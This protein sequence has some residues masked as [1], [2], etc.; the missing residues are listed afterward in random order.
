MVIQLLQRLPIALAHHPA[1]EADDVILH[2][3][4]KAIATGEKRIIVVS[5]DSDFTQLLQLDARPIP[6]IHDTDVIVHNWRDKC[7]L[8]RP[9]FDYVLWKALRGDPTD[10]VPRC[11]GVTE[12]SAMVLANDPI[13]L[14]KRMNDAVFQKELRRNLEIIRLKDLSDD[15]TKELSITEGVPDWEWV[16]QRFVEFDFKSML[17]EPSW[18]RYRDAFKRLNNRA[19]EG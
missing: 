13:I 11:T 18:S 15:D 17:K 16:R 19:V 9:D 14:S 5:S 6:V 4:I 1:F 10:N 12:A 2:L 7:D 3:V 8:T